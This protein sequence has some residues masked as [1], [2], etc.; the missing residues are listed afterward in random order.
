[1]QLIITYKIHKLKVHEKM[2]LILQVMEKV[3]LRPGH[4][5]IRTYCI[6]EIST[7][8]FLIT[9]RKQ[10]FFYEGNDFSEG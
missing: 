6:I 7:F 1:M 8:K 10:H 5:K 4:L 2:D 9:F 3:L